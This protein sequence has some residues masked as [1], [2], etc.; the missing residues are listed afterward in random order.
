[1]VQS[2]P[3]ELSMDHS[4]ILQQAEKNQ[5]YISVSYLRKELNWEKERSDKALEYLMNQGLAWV[6][7]Q[8][9]QEPLYYF[10]SLFTACINSVS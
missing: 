6:D 5:A 8:N 7:S 3:G 10:P 1:M 4:T 2:V 9:L